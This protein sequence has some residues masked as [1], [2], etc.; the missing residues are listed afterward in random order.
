MWGQREPILHTIAACGTFLLTQFP[1]PTDLADELANGPQ[2]AMRLLKRS[3]YNAVD[4]TFEQAGDDIA[5]KTAI[6]ERRFTRSSGI[7]RI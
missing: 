5:A 6:S 1:E 2:V 3:L 7:G 4:Q